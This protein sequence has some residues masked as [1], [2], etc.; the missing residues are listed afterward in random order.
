MKPFFRRVN[1]V[2]AGSLS[3]VIP[4]EITNELKISGGD[5]L[6]I[7]VFGDQIILQKATP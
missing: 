4:K 6:R 3:I 7:T 5:S 1:P 2:G